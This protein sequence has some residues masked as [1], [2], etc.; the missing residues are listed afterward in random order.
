[1]EIRHQFLSELLM[2]SGPPQK[3]FD[4]LC[5]FSKVYFKGNP[6]G[7]VGTCANHSGI[8]A[9]CIICTEKCDTITF[10]IYNQM[11]FFWVCRV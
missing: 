7:G 2:G 10:I 5:Y 9:E 4:S 6:S 11:F 3:Y 1:L 8:L